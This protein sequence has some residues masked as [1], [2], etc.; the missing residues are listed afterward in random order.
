MTSAVAGLYTKHTFLDKNSHSLAQTL[1]R[2]SSNA[3]P[4]MQPPCCLLTV[5]YTVI[6]HSGE[7]FIAGVVKQEQDVPAEHK[8]AQT[9]DVQWRHLTAPYSGE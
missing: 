4:L 3:P 8:G 7:L 2:Y 9:R 5:Q 1:E 6:H